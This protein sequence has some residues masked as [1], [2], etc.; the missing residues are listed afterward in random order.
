[1]FKDKAEFEMCFKQSALATSYAW[2]LLPT[3]VHDSAS[4]CLGT[5]HVGL[6]DDL[7]QPQIC[8]QCSLFFIALN[9]VQIAVCYCALHAHAH[10][11][12]AVGDTQ[13]GLYDISCQASE[14][15]HLL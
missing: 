5:K 13:Y 12:T 1:M 7:F 3:P 15:P 9:P 8:D 11:H 10:W 6:S 14:E 2:Y 4:A